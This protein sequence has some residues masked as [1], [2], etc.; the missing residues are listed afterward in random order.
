MEIKTKLDRLNENREKRAKRQANIDK[1]KKDLEEAR[2]IRNVIS[3]TPGASNERQAIQ[4]RIQ[5]LKELINDEQRAI[6]LLE[7]SEAETE[8]VSQAII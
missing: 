1:L 7:T 4:K 6:N 8:Q 5:N 3:T 2:D